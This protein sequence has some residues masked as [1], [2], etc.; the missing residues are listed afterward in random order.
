MS[1]IDSTV[2]NIRRP[3]IQ[4]ENFEI[5][6]TIIQMIQQSV[7]FGSL[8]QED[9]NID[10][11]NFLEISDTSKHNGVTDKAIH[12]SHFSFFLRDNMNA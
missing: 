4:D 2:S 8:S 3:T 10:I 1:S 7:Q 9:S 11:T 6:L 5:K 12:V